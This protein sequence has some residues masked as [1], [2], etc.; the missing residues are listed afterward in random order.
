MYYSCPSPVDDTTFTLA[1]SF[2]TITPDRGDRPR[3]MEFCRHQISRFTVKPDKSYFIDYPPK[4]ETKDLVERVQVGIEMAKADAID[5]VFIIESD[6]YYPAD[7][8]ER[9]DMRSDIV[10]DDRTIYYHIGNNGFSHERHPFHASLFTTGF[11][12]S[13][14]DKFNYNS[15]KGVWLDVELWRHARRRKLNNRFFDS[16][17]VGIKHGIGLTGGIGHRE[18]IYKKFDK[19]WKILASMVDA[20]AL[21]F[22]MEINR[23]LCS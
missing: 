19:D 20:D 17:C 3:F 13:S 15:V 12:L 2:A 9:I 14:F 11:R 8:F 22:Y 21:D 16:G 5:K 23:E 18:R 6:D 7:Y 1:G 4:S 10:G